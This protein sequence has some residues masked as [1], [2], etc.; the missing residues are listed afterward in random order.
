MTL[1]SLFWIK[2]GMTQRCYV[3]WSNKYMYGNLVCARRQRALTGTSWMTW[4]YTPGAHYL[5][6]PKNSWRVIAVSSPYIRYCKMESFFSYFRYGIQFSSGCWVGWIFS[7][8]T[9]MSEI[10]RATELAI[11]RHSR[12]FWGGKWSKNNLMGI[13]LKIRPIW[14]PPPQM[15]LIFFLARQGDCQ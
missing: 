10:S 9:K 7:R 14:L 8:R 12:E 1:S 5:Y 6:T 2:S 3:E 4:W 15:F 11:S 13:T